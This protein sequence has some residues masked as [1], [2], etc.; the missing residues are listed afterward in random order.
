MRKV[1]GLRNKKPAMARAAFRN[2]GRHIT[3]MSK[4]PQLLAYMLGDFDSQIVAVLRWHIA[5]KGRK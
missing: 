3:V 4:G 5:A 1:C 2:G